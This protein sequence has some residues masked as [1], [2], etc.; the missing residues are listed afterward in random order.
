MTA[1][2]PHG[3]PIPEVDAPEEKSQESPWIQ[4]T[5]VCKCSNATDYLRLGDR[6]DALENKIKELKTRVEWMENYDKEDNPN[7]SDDSSL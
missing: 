1:N 7:S 2:N 3:D 5:P 6:V 4:L